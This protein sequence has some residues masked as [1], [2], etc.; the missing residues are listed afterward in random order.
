MGY[1]IIHPGTLLARCRRVRRLELLAYI[2]PICSMEYY[3]L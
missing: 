1:L 3:E 2:R